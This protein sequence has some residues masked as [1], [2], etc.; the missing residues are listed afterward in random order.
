MQLSAVLLLS[1]PRNKL[2]CALAFSQRARPTGKVP[3]ANATVKIIK[4]ATGEVKIRTNETEVV[5]SF[6]N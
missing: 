2:R 3:L 5:I 6:F 4:L 1:R